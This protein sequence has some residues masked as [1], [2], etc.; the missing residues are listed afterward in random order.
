MGP[1]GGQQC[2]KAAVAPGGMLA[3]RIGKEVTSAVIDAVDC[4]VAQKINPCVH[5]T[6]DNIFTSYWDCILMERHLVETEL[7]TYFQAQQESART[8]YQGLLTA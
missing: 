7:K 1:H 2:V 6:L 3:E 5:K 4:I 8:E